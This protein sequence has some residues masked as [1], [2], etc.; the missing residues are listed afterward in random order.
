MSKISIGW[1]VQEGTG[2]ERKAVRTFE[3][4]PVNLFDTL[5]ETRDFY[6]DTFVLESL[7]GSSL[8]VQ[9]QGHM[10]ARS[11][12]RKEDDSG[13]LYSDAELIKYAGT[14]KPDTSIR[15]SMYDAASPEVL[16]ARAIVKAFEKSIKAKKDESS[17]TLVK[18]RK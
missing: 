2:E 14:Y 13:W 5:K 11:K 15:S 17:G 1:T 16:K 3:D 18:E 6:G 7:N 12:A 8:V 4:V 9:I 10:R